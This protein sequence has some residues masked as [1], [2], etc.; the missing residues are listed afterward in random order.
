MIT[1]QGAKALNILNSAIN[2]AENNK[3]CYVDAKSI[4]DN[5]T[6]TAASA[7][8][9]ATDASAVSTRRI[10]LSLSFCFSF[11]LKLK[12]S[13]YCFYNRSNNLNF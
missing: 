3:M 5:A 11:S 4:I 13:S 9:K 2:N 10:F 1:G 6:A 8:L 12:N 7:R